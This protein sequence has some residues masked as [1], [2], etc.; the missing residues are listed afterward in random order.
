[1]FTQ[2]K[3]PYGLLESEKCGVVDYELQVV[4]A[5][6]LPDYIL[7]LDGYTITLNGTD[8]D[9][10]IGTYDA[11]LVVKIVEYNQFFIQR[12]KFAIQK[13]NVETEDQI[14]AEINLPPY[15]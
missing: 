13:E 2:F 5:I 6:K 9:A 15:F 10:F 4:T 7:V 8:A 12:F 14:E 11:E 3:D 1:M